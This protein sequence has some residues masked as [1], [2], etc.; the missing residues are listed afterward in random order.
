MSQAQIDLLD[1]QVN[2]S[3]QQLAQIRTDNGSIQASADKTMD[4]TTCMLAL[5]LMLV[6]IAVLLLRS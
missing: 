6:A 2:A 4:S 5:V 1:A 3:H